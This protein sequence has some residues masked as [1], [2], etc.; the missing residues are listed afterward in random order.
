MF[1]YPDGIKNRGGKLMR[2]QFNI[3]GYIFAFPAFIMVVV[4]FLIP[5]AENVFYS[6][7]NWN[8]IT[9]KLFI[10]L[11]NYIDLVKDEN[12]VKSMCN[13]LLWVV[14]TIVFSVGMGLIIAVFVKD[15]KG[16]NIFKSIF[17]APL[18][19]S[20]VCTGA[21]WLN[22]FGKEF[23]VI[24]EILSVLGYKANIAWLFNIPLNT[25]SLLVAWSWQQLGVSLVLFLVGLTSLPAE[26]IEASMI[27][28]C[29][30]WQTF[31]HVTLPMLKPITT[32]VVG[33]AIVNSF[34]AFDLVFI[35]TRGGPIRSSE[36]LA[37]TMFV[38]A[39]ERSNRGYGA[40][41]AVFLSLVI[42]PITAIYIRVTTRTELAE[43]K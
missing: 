16:A 7:F 24:N 9:P 37:V 31:V 21:I 42:L 15:I 4:L 38:E 29:N 1:T 12:F 26:Q 43:N 32:V 13:T 5:M 34:K 25:I 33:M 30:K 14:F 22:M 28:G 40:A 36:T 23:G 11:Q 41:I 20:F 2:K 6:F 18:T 19:I 27:D 39:F 10:G 35:M 17:F 3:W 8:G